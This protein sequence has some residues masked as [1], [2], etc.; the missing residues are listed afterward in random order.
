MRKSD[1]E[2]VKQI[3]D[4][5]KRIKDKDLLNWTLKKA[6]LFEIDDKSVEIQ[7]VDLNNFKA[8]D[9]LIQ[10]KQDLLTLINRKDFKSAPYKNI[11]LIS[12]LEKL[13]LKQF[14][15]HN[16]IK[17]KFDKDIRLYFYDKSKELYKA[18]YDVDEVLGVAIDKNLRKTTD[19]IIIK[20]L[21]S[22]QKISSAA[23]NIM[24]DHFIYRI[25]ATQFYKNAY[26]LIN[27]SDFKV[28]SKCTRQNL[29]KISLKEG[30]DQS[31]YSAAIDKC[32]SFIEKN[33]YNGDHSRI[34]EFLCLNKS[35]N[36]ENLEKLFKTGY[37]KIL[38]E[39][40]D[41][42]MEFVKKHINKQTYHKHILKNKNL[43]KELRD[44]IEGIRAIK[45]ILE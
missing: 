22:K 43:S 23:L 15:D 37:D 1:K 42:P 16:F 45:D 34:L 19:R 27:R 12:V 2:F 7:K 10:S 44:Q 40:D 14:I 20:I 41:I 26:T 17:S 28:S 30:L 13:L 36:V 11:L 31:V 39:R 35:L 33:P 29:I 25:Y 4:F 24:F 3:Y 21:Q 6:D 38:C 9:K 5:A 8:I 32:L 18:N